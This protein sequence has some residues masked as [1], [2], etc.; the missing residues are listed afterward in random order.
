MDG[1]DLKGTRSEEQWT[2]AV[3]KVDV[4]HKA[5]MLPILDKIKL[6]WYDKAFCLDRKPSQMKLTD[7]NNVSNILCV[8]RLT[9]FHSTLRPDNTAGPEWKSPNPEQHVLRKELPEV[10]EKRIL[11]VRGTEQDWRFNCFPEVPI[12]HE[13]EKSSTNLDDANTILREQFKTFIDHDAR[14]NFYFLLPDLLGLF[15]SKLGIAPP[16]ATAQNF[17]I[18]IVAL[19]ARWV[20][21]LLG[22]ESTNLSEDDI[23]K[24]EPDPAFE[25]K[26]GTTPKIA[27]LANKNKSEQPNMYQIT[28]MEPTVASGLPAVFSLGASIGG[29]HGQLGKRNFGGLFRKARW[30]ICDRDKELANMVANWKWPTSKQKIIKTMEW[31]WAKDGGSLTTHRYGN[32]GETYTF[33]HMLS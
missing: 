4:K 3:K 31:K 15:F 13:L 28:W 21:V 8:A 24:F 5:E 19:Y 9:L 6:L 10:D 7:S 32:C 30:D 23:A 1:I 33:L 20:G 22:G 27:V 18:P 12:G 25:P 29:F 14:R 26:D 11:H 2:D 16:L 17:Y